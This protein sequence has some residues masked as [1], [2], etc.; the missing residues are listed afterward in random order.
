MRDRG[1]LQLEK[2][3][4]S[5][6]TVYFFNLPSSYA[7][8][9]KSIWRTTTG[10]NSSTSLLRGPTTQPQAQV[11]SVNAKA[12]RAIATESLH[13]FFIPLGIFSI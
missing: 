5:E 1:S 6:T 12:A 8:E 13:S 9:F 3:R 2:N 7:A 11:S 10:S 4:L